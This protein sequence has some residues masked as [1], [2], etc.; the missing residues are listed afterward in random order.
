MNNA[1]GSGTW[2]EERLRDRLASQ[3]V[4]WVVQGRM[5][6]EPGSEKLVSIVEFWAP[7]TERRQFA[8]N[9]I[10][11]SHRAGLASPSSDPP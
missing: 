5:W 8:G 2:S 11:S 3:K 1:T 10:V 9:V 6:A 7:T 4:V